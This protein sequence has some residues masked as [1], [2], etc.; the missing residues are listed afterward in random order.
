M[1]NIGT[2]KLLFSCMMLSSQELESQRNILHSWCTNNPFLCMCNV[3]GGVFIL[4]LRIPT[5]LTGNTGTVCSVCWGFL[6]NL[7]HFVW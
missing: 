3:C 1:D 2:E 5:I 6:W 4:V 7:G